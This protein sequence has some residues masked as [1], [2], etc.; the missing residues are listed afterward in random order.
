MKK[1]YNIEGVKCGGCASVVKEKLSAI[2]GVE[3]V[4]VNVEEKTLSIEGYVDK[5]ILNQALADT[6]FKIVE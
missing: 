2:S 4:E 6:K 5:E 1:I 3:L